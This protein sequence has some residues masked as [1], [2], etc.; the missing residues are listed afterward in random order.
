L[1]E[2]IKNVNCG[3]SALD[4][5]SDLFFGYKSGMRNP[6]LGLFKLLSTF[7]AIMLLASCS[8]LRTRSDVE[9]PPFVTKVPTT[10]E[11]STKSEA[12][13]MPAPLAPEAKVALVLGPGGYKALAH[14]QVVKELVQAKIPVQKV[15]GI[16]WGSLAAAFFALEGKAHEA[17]WKL[18]KLDT[19]LLESKSFFS[20]SISE[21]ELRE[22]RCV[23][24]CGSICLPAA[25]IKVGSRAVGTA[26]VA[27]RYR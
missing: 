23:V 9:T 14:A 1:S 27:Y 11:S 20:K 24:A 25:F 12:T 19:A 6:D 3:K 2:K 16:E 8:Q 4:L 17:E 18:Y 21:R 5:D 13:P 7:A 22:K 10:G 26:W 15:V